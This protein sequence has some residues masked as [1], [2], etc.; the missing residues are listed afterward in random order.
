MISLVSRFSPDIQ[1]GFYALQRSVATNSIE[2]KLINNLTSLQSDNSKAFSA[3]K[4]PE[5][6]AKEKLKNTQQPAKTKN[7]VKAPYELAHLNTA[8]SI[9]TKNA[10]SNAN[11]NSNSILYAVG[12]KG[13]TNIYPDVADSPAAILRKADMLRSSALTTAQPSKQDTHV[14]ANAATIYTKTQAVGD[15][16]K[17]NTNVIVGALSTTPMEVNAIKAP[18]QAPQIAATAM[19]ART[20]ADLLQKNQSTQNGAN[21]HLGSKIDLRA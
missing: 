13:K 12:D 19:A 20:Q 5:I 1:Q 21:D 18:E 15:H 8:G 6:S 9:S 17:I 10:V 3:N 4:K 11:K 7:E 2:Q 14:A 16:E